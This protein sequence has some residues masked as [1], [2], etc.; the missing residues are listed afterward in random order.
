MQVRGGPG[1]EPAWCWDGARYD[2]ELMLG[3]ESGYFVQ[4]LCRDYLGLDPVKPDVEREFQALAAAASA[5][6]ADF[7]LHR[8]F[9]S[10]NIMVQGERAGF[11]DFQAGRLGPLAYDLAS[12]LI[13]PYAALPGDFQEEL[14]T[15]YLQGLHRF[16]PYDHDRF[17]REFLVLA[18]QRNLQILGAFA[19]L[20]RQRQRLFF[21][22]Y[23][24]P[25]LDSL[26]TLLAK[27]AAAG[28]PALRRLAGQCSQQLKTVH[29]L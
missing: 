26:Q 22:R 8:D 11:I 20:T 5:A 9:Q 7:F 27:P 3:R 13:D 2:Q 23:L 16:I 10:R 15:A 12:L 29:D 1:L 21:R 25:A 18:L 4:A 28:Y 6:P 17:R 14:L 24:R 19:F